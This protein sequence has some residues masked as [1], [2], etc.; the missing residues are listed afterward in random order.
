MVNFK[1]YEL[2]QNVENYFEN[3]FVI[4]FRKEQMI[5]I[6][7]LKMHGC[8]CCQSMSVFG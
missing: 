8:A 3:P 4:T 7:L 5:Q 6:L 1:L 2:L